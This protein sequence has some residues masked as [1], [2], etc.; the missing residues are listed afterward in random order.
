MTQTQTGY[1]FDTVEA[2]EKRRLDDQTSLWDSFTFQRLAA[3]G[4]GEGWRCLEI[5]GGTGSVAR[6]LHDE[7]GDR[8][9]VVVTDLET[10]WLEPLAA[11]NLE[12]RCHDVVGDPIE[13]SSYDL[14]HARLVLMHLPEREAVVGKLAGALRPGGWLVVEDYDGHTFGVTHPEHPPWARVTDA[15][16]RALELAGADAYWGSRMEGTLRAAGLAEVDVQGLALAQPAPQLA[17]WA[18]PIV[19]RLR[20]RL[21]DAGLATD[22]EID[23]ATAPFHDD[24]SDLSVFSPILVSARGQRGL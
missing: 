11:P 3:T 7:V 9:H 16:A 17:P 8:G 15:I 18:L 1:V 19:G 23:Q 12:V 20:D 13:S 5:G 22:A 6:W 4:L 21:V 24:A 14:I 2:T 10:R